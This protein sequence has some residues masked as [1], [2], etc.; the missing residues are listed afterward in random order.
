MKVHMDIFLAREKENT[1]SYH[2]RM[3]S[4]LSALKSLPSLF[5]VTFASINLNI[6]NLVPEADDVKN[7]SQTTRTTSNIVK[8]SFLQKEKERILAD[9]SLAWDW[10]RLSFLHPLIAFSCC[11]LPLLL[12]VEILTKLIVRCCWKVLIPNVSPQYTE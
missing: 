11:L 10:W 4:L 12:V 6:T 5:V 1:K 2:S 8:K 7:I 3:K 9:Y